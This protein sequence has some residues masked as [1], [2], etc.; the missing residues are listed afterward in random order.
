M[1]DDTKHLMSS[2]R[3]AER[4]RAAIAQLNAGE[5]VERKLLTVREAY[6]DT[7]RRFPKTM[8]LLSE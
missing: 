7:M 3:N 5:G 4:L 1:R 8:K 2:P 6:R